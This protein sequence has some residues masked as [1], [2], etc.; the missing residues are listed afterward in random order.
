MAS[1][2]VT[3]IS[4]DFYRS[5]RAKK[6]SIIELIESC[7]D[8][9]GLLQDTSARNDA[10][11]AVNSLS[12]E[13]KRLAH[14]LPPYDRQAYL[15]E[16]DQ[17]YALLDTKARA[18]GSRF[19]FSKKALESAKTEQANERKAAEEHRATASTKKI[20][21]PSMP[22]RDLNEF[23]VNNKSHVMVC[24]STSG[25]GSNLILANVDNSVIVLKPPTQFATAKLDYITNSVIYI[26]AVI[27][28]I[29]LNHISH[30][31][32]VA[33]CHQFRMHES[34]STDVFLGCGSGRPIIE[35]CNDLRFAQFRFQS[36]SMPV[37]D[38]QDVDDFNWLVGGQ[39]SV[40]WQ[41]LPPNE[42]YTN[43]LEQSIANALA[44]PT[45]LSE[46]SEGSDNDLD[47]KIVVKD[48]FPC[49]TLF[50]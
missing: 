13:C 6:A 46:S 40:N 34:K 5:F 33:V 27:G 50:E 37:P 28:P 16:L 14:A 48:E 2:S 4:A 30:C 38:W 7:R 26:D 32:I 25:G 29:Y 9:N 18:K 36:T 22:A 35:Q 43:L 3:A 21:I 15:Q 45:P 20:V 17:L 10:L 1:S 47:R 49:V 31:V 12:D 24:N 44:K 41:P 42:D 39:Q 23:I 8:Q 19:K 11:N